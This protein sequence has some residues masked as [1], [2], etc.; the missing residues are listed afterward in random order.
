MVSVLS[1]ASVSG[2]ASEVVEDESFTLKLLGVGP[3]ITARLS[4]IMLLASNMM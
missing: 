1:S 2:R 4:I 3:E